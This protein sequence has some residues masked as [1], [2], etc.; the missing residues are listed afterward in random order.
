M[1][2]RLFAVVAALVTVSLTAHAD[3][4]NN[5][6]AGGTFTD[7]ATLSG[8]I[9]M[10]VTNGTVLSADLTVGSPLDYTFTDVYLTAPTPGNPND[11]E[12]LLVTPSLYSTLPSMY[13]GLDTSSLVGYTGGPLYSISF[14]DPYYFIAGS[15]INLDSDASQSLG[16]SGYFM[17]EGDLTLESSTTTTP[18]PSSIALLGTGLLCGAGVVRR[19]TMERYTIVEP[20]E[21]S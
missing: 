2:L 8:T 19:R 14:L 15:V 17:N 5:F 18:E 6:A 3:T 1:R 7:G 4:I 20:T 13:L 16:V 9:D 11:F 10:D 12:I 21:F